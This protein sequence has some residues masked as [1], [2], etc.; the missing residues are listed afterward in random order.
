MGSISLRVAGSDLGGEH[1]VPQAGSSHVGRYPRLGRAA[2]AGLAAA[3]GQTG[4][5]TSVAR[6]RSGT[7][8]FAGIGGPAAHQESKN[9]EEA[10]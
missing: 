9:R 8:C 6:L 5:S 4:R 3:G 10:T 7:L 2:L 1:R